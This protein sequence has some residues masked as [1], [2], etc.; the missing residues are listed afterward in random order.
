ME[1]QDTLKSFGRL[2]DQDTL[3]G[4]IDEDMAPDSEG[5]QSCRVIG[6]AGAKGGV[7]TTTVAINVAMML[8]QA[9]QK[10]IYLELS[11]HPGSAARLFQMPQISALRESAAT[12]EDINAEFVNQ[13]LMNHST[14]LR[15]LGLS[16]WAQEVGHQVS[17]EL[18][19]VLFRE[20]K[21]LADFLVLDFPLEPS[22]PSIFFLR[23]CQIL[24][25][26]TECDPLCLDLAKN[27]LA[28]VLSHGQTPVYITPVNRSG[29]PPN[30]GPQGI[31][32]QL[33]HETPVFIPAAPELCH[34]ASVKKM[35]I[36]CINPNSVPAL[37]FTKLTERL[38]AH[39]TE[40]ITGEKL[41]R[42]GRDR[43]KKDRRNREAW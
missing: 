34:T 25:L 7:G 17:P 39:F 6:F 13:L 18:L 14:G 11:P 22:F 4:V 23:Q 10:V 24:D 37:Q 30:E 31:Q 19:T 8:V 32:E 12:L 28:F 5:N 35:P 20:L 3:A 15:V 16:P 33:G 26:V 9:G 21:N 41:N 42:R 29:I 1:M 2:K 36:V 27:Q 38:F 43:R 40:E